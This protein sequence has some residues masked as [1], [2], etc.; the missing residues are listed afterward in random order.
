MTTLAERKRKLEDLKS[1]NV[2]WINKQDLDNA[3]A[4]VDMSIATPGAAQAVSGKQ[5]TR[6]NMV[7]I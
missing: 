5:K 2:S 1:K 3:I 6:I 7:T 4:E